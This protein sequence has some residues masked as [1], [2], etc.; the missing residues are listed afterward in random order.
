MIVDDSERFLRAAIRRFEGSTIEVV[1]TAR[2]RG[3]A[4]RAAEEFAPDLAL[5]DV[6]L[7]E[8]DGVALARALARDHSVPVILISASATLASTP[9][10]DASGA[11]GFIPKGQ[12]GAEAIKRLLK[13]CV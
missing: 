5:V 11:R 1:A 3:E 12:L 6:G 10:V 7:G 13:G 9:A 2:N 4:H 8:E